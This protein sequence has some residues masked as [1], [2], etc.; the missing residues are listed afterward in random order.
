[1]L[2]KPQFPV[3]AVRRSSPRFDLGAIRTIHLQVPTRFLL[4]YTILFKHLAEE[5]RKRQKVDGAAYKSVGF[6]YGE[7][8]DPALDHAASA[9]T[10]AP[11]STDT[12]SFQPPYAVPS[13]LLDKM[14]SGGL[15]EWNSFS[16]MLVY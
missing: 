2:L 9:A 11:P 12:E 5:D 8:A 15:D 6:S 4:I 13:E 3:Q 7:A 16:A 10:P 14:V 1:M